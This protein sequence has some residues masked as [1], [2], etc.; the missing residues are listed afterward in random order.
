MYI[1]SYDVA[2]KSLA[3]ALVWINDN[4]QTDLEQATY[5]GV[6]SINEA[7]S[8]NDQNDIYK[9]AIDALDRIYDILSNIIKPVI[10]DVVDL[11][12]GKKV[13]E[14]SVVLRASRLNGYLHML[15][16]VIKQ[17]TNN[18]IIKVLI[19]YQMGPNDQSRN[20]GSQILSHYIASDL[21]F[22]SCNFQPCGLILPKYDVSI[23]GPSLKNQITLIKG[24]ELSHFIQKY[25][26]NYTAN[27]AHSKY[28]FLT[29]LKL[30][31]H[32]DL[33]KNIK[34]ANH[35]DIADAFN[36]CLSWVFKKSD[37]L[38]PKEQYHSEASN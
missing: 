34:L 3:V 14:T 19:E 26:K 17:T 16:S 25:T 20:V 22:E 36:Q 38:K 28:N 18:K 21:N 6:R 24:F 37:I 8:T 9:A 10:F 5:D 35:D 31:K 7:S 11:I 32:T 4:W 33:L 12:P 27:K 15:D 13:K 23:V 2:S 1:I 30:N 29:W